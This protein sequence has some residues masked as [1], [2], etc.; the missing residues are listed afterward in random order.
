MIRRSIFIPCLLVVSLLPITDASACSKNFLGVCSGKCPSSKPH[1]STKLDL[2]GVRCECVKK[3]KNEFSSD[4][5][6]APEVSA[7]P[8]IEALLDLSTETES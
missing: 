5:V 3:T 1:C 2:G 4:A 6:E 7:D 8:L